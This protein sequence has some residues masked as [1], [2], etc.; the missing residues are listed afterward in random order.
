MLEITAVI[1][2]LNVIIAI[3]VSIGNRYNIFKFPNAIEYLYRYVV[4]GF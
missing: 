4:N 3:I 2:I 1:N